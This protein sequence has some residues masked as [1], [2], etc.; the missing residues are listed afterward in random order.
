[1]PPTP[2][3]RP[4]DYVVEPTLANRVDLEAQSGF[5]RRPADDLPDLG[6][7]GRQ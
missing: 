2:G 4:K 6:F 5:T 3:P 7:V 1:M